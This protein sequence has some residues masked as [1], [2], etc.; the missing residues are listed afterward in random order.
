MHLGFNNV[1]ATP[2]LSLPDTHYGHLNDIERHWVVLLPYLGSGLVGRI[3]LQ[4]WPSTRLCSAF[5]R[6]LFLRLQTVELEY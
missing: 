4:W 6:Y 2:S 1:I 5:E 3:A